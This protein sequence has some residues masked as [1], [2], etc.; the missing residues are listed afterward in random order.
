MAKWFAGL[1]FNLARNSA[2]DSLHTNPYCLRAYY[3]NSEAAKDIKFAKKIRQNNAFFEILKKKAKRDFYVLY[4]ILYLMNVTSSDKYEKQIEWQ[5]VRVKLLNLRPCRIHVFTC[6]A[7]LGTNLLVAF[8]CFLVCS[9]M[10]EKNADKEMRG[11]KNGLG[12][13]LN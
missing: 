11:M 13:L 8:L 12:K 5:C 6:I 3:W 7:L 1:I 10:D 9:R 4:N 2:V